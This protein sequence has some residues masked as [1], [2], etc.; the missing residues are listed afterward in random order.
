MF[1]QASVILSTEGGG[2]GCIPACIAGG[3]TACLASGL[4]GVCV[5]QHALHQVGLFREGGVS[6]LTPM[7]E[8]EGGSDPG[9]HPRGK[10][11]GI[12]SRPTPKREIE[13]DQIQADGTHPTGMYS[14]CKLY[15]RADAGLLLVH[16]ELI[17]LKVHSM[18]SPTV[19]HAAT[20]AIAIV[21][22]S[23]EL[24]RDSE[25]RLV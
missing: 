23:L 17:L 22:F 21:H 5:S 24:K 15:S 4:Q 10:L 18:K 12:R 7:V 8:I 3:I 2:G 6:R 11:R 19:K 13:G 25:Y 20:T 16:M 9:P 14:C 1:L